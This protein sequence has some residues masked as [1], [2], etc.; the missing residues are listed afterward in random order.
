MLSKACG[1]EQ[2][3]SKVKATSLILSFFE[4]MRFGS[5]S[6]AMWAFC[7]SE[8]TGI[9]ISKQAIFSRMSRSWVKLTSQLLEQALAQHL[10]QRI[11]NTLLSRFNRVLVQDSTTFHLPDHLKSCYKGNVSQGKVKSVAKL[12]LVTD[13]LTGQFLHLQ[14]M[15]FTRTE[16]A[17]SGTIL[18]IACRGDLIIRDLGYSVL[19]VFKQMDEAGIFFLSRL[20]YNTGL[21]DSLTGKPFELSKALR[22]QKVMDK[23]VLCGKDHQVK[24]RLVAIKLSDEQAAERRRK[25]RKDR[26]R[27]L[28]HSKE[29][30][31][32]LGYLFFITNV[33]EDIWDTQQVAQVYRT[34]WDIEILFKSWKSGMNMK[35]FIPKDTHRTEKT[36]GTLYLIMLYALWFQTLI[37][38][39]VKEYAQKDQISIIKLARIAMF[40]QQQWMS[41]TSPSLIKEITKYAKYDIRHDRVNAQQQL[42]DCFH[43]LA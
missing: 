17:L 30:Y 13:I 9:R 33:G 11:S 41:N 6:Y 4:M 25:A 15:D 36:E 18:D 32:L 24:V 2:R 20:K 14:W 22:G 37:Y 7:L 39:P 21:T 5:S 19:S 42:Q 12:N 1:F 23:W 38:I 31:E 26:D 27:R 16:Q 3:K 34:R 40:K 10:A 28:N 29:Y 8:L 35:H 43:F